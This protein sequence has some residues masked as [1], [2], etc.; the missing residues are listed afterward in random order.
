MTS[1]PTSPMRR[2]V[3]SPGRI[4]VV[5]AE[6]PRPGAGE[7]LVRTVLAGVCGSDTHAAAGH[8]PFVPLPYRPGHEVVG[9]VTALG[10]DAGDLAPGDRVT[11]E[12]TLP[13]GACKMC[14]TGR[15]NLCENLRFFGCGWEQGAMAD[16]F[17]APADRLHRIP[18]TIGDLDATLVEPLSS[19]VHAVRL[20]GDLTGA[21]V[22]VLG[23]GTIGLLTLA[24]VRRAG[25]RAVVMTDPLPA[26]RELALR[27]GADAV[28]D[29]R[30]DDVVAQVRS[31]LGE[32]ADAVFDCVA[33][34]FTVPQAVGMA[35][36]AGTVVVVGV[37]A[38]DVAV[39]L[40]LIQDQQVRLQG[41]ATYL[42]EDIAVATA[43]V[44]AGEVRA[45]DLVT[46]E[47]PLDDVAAAF[48]ASASGAH[49]KVV[50]RA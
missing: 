37:P 23:C 18:D 24:A 3:V 2:V 13:C 44:A 5:A 16:W 31:A 1:T 48:A 14:R 35:L 41:S 50:L 45:A 10:H 25:A 34:R 8:H 4:E 49:V 40:A 47:F 39:P 11:L 42:A 27:L 30:A 46:A 36:K 26:K 9:V 29:A 20:A 38:G 6:V 43:M 19:P 33:N 12:P 15:S 21:A 7:V 32:S 17:T 28:V 22:A